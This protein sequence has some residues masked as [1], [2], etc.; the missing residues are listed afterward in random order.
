M[1]TSEGADASGTS[2]KYSPR[3]LVIVD[4][5]IDSMLITASAIG[6]P[7]QRSVTLPLKPE[8]GAETEML[9]VT[10]IGIFRNM[11]MEMVKAKRTRTLRVLKILQDLVF[12]R[13]FGI[14]RLIRLKRIFSKLILTVIA[15]T[16]VMLIVFR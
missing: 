3:E 13:Y 2:N 8:M 6:S 7:E 12:K 14:I 4:T 10:V 5:P 16:L 9:A 15:S 1:S 11:D